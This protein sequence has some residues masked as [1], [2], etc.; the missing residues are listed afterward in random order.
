MLIFIFLIITIILL[1]LCDNGDDKLVT[2]P[3]NNK[4][5]VNEKF[6]NKKNVNETFVNKNN[7]NTQ[8]INYP[9]IEYIDWKKERRMSDSLTY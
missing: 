8:S 3:I 5:N 1:I 6:N 4:K 9:Y 7:Y 2:L